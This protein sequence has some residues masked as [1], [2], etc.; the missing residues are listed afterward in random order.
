MIIPHLITLRHEIN[1]ESSYYMIKIQTVS[2]SKDVTFTSKEDEA[3]I[4]LK[5]MLIIVKLVKI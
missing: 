3:A 5:E 1:T 2:F 4:Q